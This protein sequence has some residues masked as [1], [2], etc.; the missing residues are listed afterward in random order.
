MGDSRRVGYGF[1]RSPADFY[2]A[3]VDD[4]YLDTA[5]TDRFELTHMVRIG[6]RDGDTLVLLR[7]SD[8]GAGKG[9]R[10]LRKALADRGVKIEIFEPEPDEKRDRGRPPKGGFDDEDWARFGRMWADPATDGGYIITKACQEMGEDQSD[11]KARERVRQRLLR[12][13]GRRDRTQI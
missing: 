3:R 1:N 13:L 4:L 12:K 5:K 6:L 8:L 7:I 9:L 11:R 10:N 2:A